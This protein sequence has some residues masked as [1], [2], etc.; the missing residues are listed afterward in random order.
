MFYLECLCKFRDAWSEVEGAPVYE[1]YQAA[2]SA[3]R[4]IAANRRTR[5]RA[6]DEYGQV[7]FI[8]P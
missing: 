3:A 4:V 2:L 8:V 5:V 1:D 7:V 6:L